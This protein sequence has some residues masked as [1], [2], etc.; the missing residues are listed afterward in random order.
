MAT[1]D[2]IRIQVLKAIS[3]ATTEEVD[4]S[5]KVDWIRLQEEAKNFLKSY[6]RLEKNKKLFSSSLFKLVM[7]KTFDKNEINKALENYNEQTYQSDIDRAIYAI[8]F[9]FNDFLDIYRNKL[10]KRV[11]IYVHVVYDEKTKKS[12]INTYSMSLPDLITLSSTGGKMG[13][14][15]LDK[16]NELSSS[17]L[18]NQTQNEKRIEHQREADQ[19]YNAVRNRVQ[20]Y[21]TRLKKSGSSARA[22]LLMWEK[23]NIWEV[24]E[25]Q[26][27]G[28]LA[29]GYVNFLFKR[30]N[31]KLCSITPG[32]PP[33]YSHDF[34]SQFYNDYLKNPTNLSAIMEEDVI[35]DNFQ[36]AVKSNYAELPDL[37]QYVNIAEYIISHDEPTNIEEE[38]TKFIKKE[39]KLNPERDLQYA[40]EKASEEIISDLQSVVDKNAFRFFN[41]NFS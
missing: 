12:T 17:K 23:N 20:E 19:A 5:I 31:Q 25:I 8:A 11:G 16:I 35:T 6:N 10:K 26:S 36:F 13:E 29:E 4:K 7:G 34:V 21:Y 3:Q 24:K 40:K 9:R 39:T 15:S 41:I 18:I 27:W 38:L 1:G 22:G 30:H 28:S 37:P 14:V 2:N 33:F 32:Y